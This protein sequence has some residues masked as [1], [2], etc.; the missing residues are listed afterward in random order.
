MHHQKLRCFALILSTGLNRS[1]STVSNAAVTILPLSTTICIWSL[2]IRTCRFLHEGTAY[3]GTQADH[4][5]EA[6]FQSVFNSTA[7]LDISCSVEQQPVHDRTN[8]ISN[9]RSQTSRSSSFACPPALANSTT[10]YLSTDHSPQQL[11]QHVHRHC[12]PSL[13]TPSPQAWHPVHAL[14]RP[15]RWKPAIRSRQERSAK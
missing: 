6:H 11:A 12:R 14:R 4:P 3:T 2:S 10:S 8:H 1:R 13:G 15:L 7:G 5:S 9:Y